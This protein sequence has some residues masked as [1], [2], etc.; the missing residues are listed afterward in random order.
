V[1][2]LASIF[3]VVAPVFSQVAA[4]LAEIA[5]IFTTIEAILDPIASRVTERLGQRG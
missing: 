4:I 5:P 3:A 1:P 2:S